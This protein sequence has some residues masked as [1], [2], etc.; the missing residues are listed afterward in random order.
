[1]STP[2]RKPALGSEFESE[3]LVRLESFQPGDVICSRCSLWKS[4]H[5]YTVCS[6]PNFLTNDGDND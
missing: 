3:V 5:D 4:E 2:A 6:E 1:M